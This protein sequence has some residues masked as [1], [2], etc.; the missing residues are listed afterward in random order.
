MVCGVLV[1]MAGQ[2]GKAASLGH[3]HCDPFLN[4]T[5]RLRAEA[6]QI[7]PYERLCPILM[8]CRVAV[9]K[10]DFR[11]STSGD[12]GQRAPGSRVKRPWALALPWGSTGLLKAPG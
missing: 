11:H 8:P 3:I 10:S 4:A 9:L 1:S 2:E 6:D 5:A 7:P 12:G